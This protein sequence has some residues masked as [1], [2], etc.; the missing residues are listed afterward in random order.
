MTDS[1][2]IAV[3]EIL[4]ENPDCV[5]VNVPLEEY[6]FCWFYLYPLNAT[7]GAV[8]INL[9]PVFLQDAMETEYT[10]NSVFSI[11]SAPAE[12]KAALPEIE[13]NIHR[14]L[15]GY[16]MEDPILLR[17]LRHPDAA[18]NRLNR[19]NQQIEGAIVRRMP[20]FRIAVSSQTQAAGG[21]RLNRM[22]PLSSMSLNLSSPSSSR[23]SQTTDNTASISRPPPNQHSSTVQPSS[24][25]STQSR[26]NLTISGSEME[27]EEQEEQEEEEE[28]NEEESIEEMRGMVEERNDMIRQL[29]DALRQAG[30]T[31]PL[32]PSLPLQQNL[33]PTPSPSQSQTQNLNQNLNQ[34]H[35]LS[36]RNDQNRE[37]SRSTAQ[38]TNQN[39]WLNQLLSLV[40]QINQNRSQ[41][42]IVI[43]SGQNLATNLDQN[44]GITTITTDQNT[45]NLNT[46]KDRD[47]NLN[48]N[49]NKERRTLRQRRHDKNMSGGRDSPSFY[50]PAPPA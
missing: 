43:G 42:G 11:D 2:A 16:L 18:S 46:T 31:N 22:P 9:M 5:L 20:D 37:T 12:F 35:T 13:K 47:P 44:Q 32:I 23:Q 4:H 49:L 27:R 1:M 10:D 45:M 41:D 33:S 25:D 6:G 39:P 24:Q 40:N 38:D 21:D 50:R 7:T 3:V 26:Q 28:E 8:A 29:S 48:R 34:S 30:I 15:Y 19:K 14:V 17:G 36:L